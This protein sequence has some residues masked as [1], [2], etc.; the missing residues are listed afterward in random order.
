MK[1]SITLALFAFGSAKQAGQ[2]TKQQDDAAPAA[3]QAATSDNSYGYEAPAQQE[4]YAPEP[5]HY[6]EAP[7]YMPAPKICVTCD[8]HAPCWNGAS[9]VPLVGED[10]GYATQEHG[11][12]RRLQQQDGSSNYATPQT[13]AGQESYGGYA[14]APQVSVSLSCPCGSVDTR[15]NRVQNNVILWVAFG[16]LFLPGLWFLFKGWDLSSDSATPDEWSALRVG[17]GVVNMVAS[18]AYLTMALGHGYVTKCNGRDFY[19]ARYVDWAITTPIMLIDIV[20]VGGGSELTI[21]FLVLMDIFMIVSGLIGELIEG[22]EKWA[23]FGFSMFAFMPIMWVLC[24]MAGI[25]DSNDGLIPS[26]TRDLFRRVA[27]ITLISWVGYPIIWILA[28]VGGASS[29]CGHAAAY[30]QEATQQAG[31]RALQAAASVSQVGVIS[32][33]GE[34]YAYTVLDIIAKT[35]MGWCIVCYD[36]AE[37]VPPSAPCRKVTGGKSSKK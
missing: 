17:A 34:A 3:P 7:T 22:S 15:W 8:D 24:T 29:H 21:I 32:V 9:C 4:S 5:E 1:T 19:Y 31:Y 33:Q 26:S 16:L 2:A 35:L 10:R 12:Y 13:Y 14:E 20:K 28:S 25:L 30:G 23:F 6:E 37:P 27:A 36:G 11:N 18:L